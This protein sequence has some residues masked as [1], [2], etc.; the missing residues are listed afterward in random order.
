M[1]RDVF[2]IPGKVQLT[3][4]GQLRTLVLNKGHILAQPFIEALKP[5]MALN[6]VH[7]ILRQI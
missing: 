4:H 1:V 6:G 3:Q 5:V 2:Q 7:L